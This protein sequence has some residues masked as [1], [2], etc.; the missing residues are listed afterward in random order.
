MFAIFVQTPEFGSQFEGVAPNLEIARVMVD[1]IDDYIEENGLHGHGEMVPLS[2]RI[3]SDV[4]SACELLEADL[5]WMA[6][7][8]MI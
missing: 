6:G 2:H 4:K 3:V 7:L 8:D 5:E 1:I